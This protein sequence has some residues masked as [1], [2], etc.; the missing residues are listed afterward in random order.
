MTEAST[1]E[2]SSDVVHTYM[3]TNHVKNQ[4]KNSLETDSN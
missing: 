1:A 4:I 2:E 3:I